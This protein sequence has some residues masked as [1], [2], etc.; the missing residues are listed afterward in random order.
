MMSRYTS[1]FSAENNDNLGKYSRLAAAIGLAEMTSVQL[2]VSGGT[3]VVWW[4]LT[5]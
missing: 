4:T 2:I 1:H 5:R 3:G